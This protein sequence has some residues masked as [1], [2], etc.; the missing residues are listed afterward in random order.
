[1]NPKHLRR[2]K[3]VATIGPASES[4]D[5]IAKLITA[6]VN[7]FRLNF[8]HGTAE[9]HIRVAARIRK[10]ASIAGQYVGVMA[11]LQGP[12][13]RISS[14]RNDAVEIASGDRFRLDQDLADGEGDFRG[15]GLEYE[16][17]CRSVA[18]GDILLL[19]DGRIRLRVD[20]V[21]ARA[22]ECTVLIGGKLGSRKGINRL[23]YYGYRQF[24]RA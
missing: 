4:E 3:I 18:R 8:S 20:D 14:F 21:E 13:I 16:A 12:K 1:M 2:T 22:V 6:G 23:G 9:H 15:V 10:Q 11:D 24:E 19:D 5:M 7:V 17:L